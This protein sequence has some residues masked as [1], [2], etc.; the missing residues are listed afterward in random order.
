MNNLI[1]IKSGSDEEDII[2]VGNNRTD[3]EEVNFQ[4]SA[5]DNRKPTENSN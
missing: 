5:E 3:S 4:R 1:V 2:L